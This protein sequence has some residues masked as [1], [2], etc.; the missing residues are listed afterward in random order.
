MSSLPNFSSFLYTQQ[1]TLWVMAAPGTSPAS[2]VQV[3]LTLPDETDVFAPYNIRNEQIVAFS[4]SYPQSYFYAYPCDANGNDI[5]NTD[6]P[7]SFP[8]YNLNVDAQQIVL[9]AAFSQ[10]GSQGGVS[11]AGFSVDVCVWT[12]KNL[13]KLDPD[14]Q[15]INF[16]YTLG[17]GGN[18]YIGKLKFESNST[19]FENLSTLSTRGATAISWGG[20]SG[21]QS[22]FTGS[23]SN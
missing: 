18:A 12:S 3:T 22:G 9:Y 20:I 2:D 10:A 8:I 15:N 4:Q 1:C 5:S 19:S 23:G 11:V 16:N 17:V 6:N 14:E 13:G 21:T 7:A